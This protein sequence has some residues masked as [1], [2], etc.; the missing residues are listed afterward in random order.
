V[1]YYPHVAGISVLS[2]VCRARGSRKH[3]FGA[4]HALG[5]D[6]QRHRH[7]GTFSTG[8]CYEEAQIYNT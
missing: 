7:Y 3:A 2:I 6:A 5:P 1:V 8:M 4:L